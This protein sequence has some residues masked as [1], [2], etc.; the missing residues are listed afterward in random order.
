MGT[1]RYLNDPEV[2]NGTSWAW[3]D[4]SGSQRWIPNSYSQYSTASYSSSVEAG[5][6]TWYF[7]SSNGVNFGGMTQS[8]SYYET[9]DISIGVK[10]VIE[11]WYLSIINN[12]GFIIK[13]QNEFINNENY[14]PSL[15]YFSRDT[16]TIYPP[17]L[18]FK[19]DDYSFNTGSST[20][21]IIN[22]LPLYTSI[23]ENPNIFYQNTINRFRINCRPQYPAR[24][25]QTASINVTNYYLPT[26]S[27]YAIQDMNTNEFIIDFDTTYTKIS[28]DSTGSYFD[29]Y[30]NGLEPERYY[31]ILI[32]TTIANST[33]VIDDDF[34]FKVING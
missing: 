22:T 6:G 21:T 33:I 12:D 10:K 20:Q 25:Y 14:Q 9:T 4:Y 29:V 3:R 23:T 24:I 28:A 19:W 16:H 8:F 32:K 27:Y 5:G 2:Q 30:M 1:G 31:K 26:A 13:Q 7:T 11:S 34:N 17:Y 18:E 15:K